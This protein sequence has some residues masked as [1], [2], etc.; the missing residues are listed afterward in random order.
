MFAFEH[1]R[2]RTGADHDE[3]AVFVRFPRL[4]DVARRLP[5]SSGLMTLLHEFFRDLRYGARL[6][7]V[8]V[9]FTATA[10]LS[11]ALGIGGATAVFS[12]VNAV[13]LRKL[14]VPHAAQLYVANTIFPRL[15]TSDMYS[16]P[17]FQHARDVLQ[18]MKAEIAA[19]TPT[20]GMQLQAQGESA[21]QR[22]Q[23]QLVS[24]EYFAAL[25]QDAEYGR[26]LMPRDNDANGGTAAAVVSD[27][28]WRKHF[29]TSTTVDGRTLTINGALFS[30]VGVTRPGFFGTTLALHNPDA[31]IPFVMQP[32][33]RYA[34]NSS[35]HNGDRQKPWAPQ[36]NVSWLNLFVRVPAGTTEAKVQSTLAEVV[37]RDEIADFASSDEGMRT[38]VRNLHVV[39]KDASS[40]VSDLRDTVST[41]LYVLLAMVGVLLVIACGNVGGLLVS[42]AAGR[43]REVAIRVSIGAGRGRLIR[44][45]LAESLLLAGVAGAL[46]VTI[47][48]WARDALFGLLVTSTTPTDLN[49]GLDVRVLAFAVGVAALTGIACGVL[50]AVRG[51]RVPAAESLKQQGRTVGIEGGRRGFVVGKALVIAQM[52]FCLLLLV[53][54]GLFGR[55]LRALAETNVGFDRDH[56]LTARIDPRAAGYPPDQRQAM[57]DRVIDRLK[58]LPGVESVSLSENGPLAN[59]ETTS[60]LAI[61]GHTP[62]PNEQLRTDEETVTTDY[63]QTVGLRVLAGRGFEP[64]DRDP[65]AHT[66]II[67]ETM[68]HR[69]FPNQSAIGKHWT[70]GE[71][72]DKNALVIVG[73]VADARYLDVKQPTP[74]MTYRLARTRPDQVLEDL[75]VRTSGSP[76]AL[77]SSVRQTLSQAEPRLPVVEVVPLSER[78][79]RGLREDRM[80]SRLTTVFGALALMLASLGL[81]GTISYGVSRRLAELAL[82]MALG[83]DRRD[84][85]W[86]VL[87]QALVLVCVGGAIGLPLAFIAARAVSTLLYNVP[88]ADPFAFSLGFLLLVAVSSLAAYLPAHRASQIEPMA[89]LNR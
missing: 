55:S 4:N 87:R 38:I 75:E 68:A 54:A 24:G 83:A 76:S 3:R 82:R 59:S 67:N 42:R 13:V 58:M 10:V 69:F 79:A 80:V 74:N 48:I 2:P 8:N 45:F 81:Y 89:A 6:L 30:I 47:A 78:I 86:L 43:E 5:S 18:P 66:S 7:R 70:Y 19:A 49:V 56:V 35:S 17:T 22:G 29:G 32:V 71:P 51:T 88:A 37:R 64:Q 21:G 52:A 63:F 65:S 16:G 34:G 53:V 26:L 31:W 25:R 36:A 44:Q 40:G 73:V 28:Y 39:L 12:L 1:E 20:A 33:V 62:A 11:L 60:S 72:I 14:P 57:Y 9:G 61:E 50:P 77:I 46:G 84:V 27:A 41:P 85:Q 15:G 23:V